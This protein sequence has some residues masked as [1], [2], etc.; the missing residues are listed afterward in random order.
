M[1]LITNT[2][3][4]FRYGTQAK[5]NKD[6]AEDLGRD[7]SS[8]RR[9]AVGVITSGLCNRARG[10]GG[11]SAIAQLMG[12]L[13]IFLYWK[14]NW[15]CPAKFKELFDC[16]H[17]ELINE[18][19][20]L[21]L[22]AEE[23]TFIFERNIGKYLA[24]GPFHYYHTIVADRISLESFKE[25][26]CRELRA[27]KPQPEILAKVDAFAHQWP[28]KVIG[29]HVRRTD[30]NQY[31]EKAK[32]SV[33]DEQAVFDAMDARLTE[34]PEVSF[35]LCTDNPSTEGF[36]RERYGERLLVYPKEFHTDSPRGLK[37]EQQRLTSVADA[38][39]DLYLLARTQ[40][41]IGTSGS[42]FSGYAG[43]LGGI[44]LQTV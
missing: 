12:G 30:L 25:L 23:E 15:A 41:L 8:C 26:F 29:V 24:T 10:I 21:K 39:I 44:E 16:P 33:S 31:L 20:Y 9:I 38:L 7:L 5:W 3:R 27:F 18:S 4:R 14:P 28:A 6:E 34:D 43:H 17:I 32:G 40:S 2:Y 11:I 35:L 13:P 37:A 36:Y 22:R 1:A 42:S 19:E